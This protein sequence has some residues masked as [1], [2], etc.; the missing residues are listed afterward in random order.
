MSEARRRL[1]VGDSDFDRLHERHEDEEDTKFSA[2][3]VA[4]ELSKV[5]GQRACLFL[6]DSEE[7]L[8]GQITGVLTEMD[9]LI[10][11]DL[12]PTRQALRAKLIV[13]VERIEHI[14][15]NDDRTK[16]KG[17]DIYADIENAMKG[18]GNVEAKDKEP[19]E[20]L[21]GTG[22]APGDSHPDP[23]GSSGGPE[24]A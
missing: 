22:G 12:R 17:C 13:P 24:A 9:A 10:V 15:T 4:Q 18:M 14:C 16:C 19:G 2:Q 1:A 5:R 6:E 11:R 23:V 3:L 20:G 21:R 7:V 8:H